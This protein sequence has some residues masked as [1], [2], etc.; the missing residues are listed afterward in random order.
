MILKNI[1]YFAVVWFKKYIT[2]DLTFLFF[3]GKVIDVD[4]GIVCEN[5]PIITPNGDVVVSSLNF[6]V[7]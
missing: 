1:M 5:V 6:K 7:R 4:K 2:S 3:L